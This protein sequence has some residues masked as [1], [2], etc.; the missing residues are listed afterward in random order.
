V[1]PDS[2]S[3][4]GLCDTVESAVTHGLSLA[5]EGADILDIGGESTRPGAPSVEAEVELRRVIPVIEG[6][7]AQCTLPLSVDT[8]KAI[9]AEAALEAGASLVND[10][11]GL[12]F[13]SK[14]ATVVARAGAGLCVMHIQG[15]PQ[16]MQDDPRY[17]NVVPVVEQFLAGAIERAVAAGV[18]RDQ[19]MVDPGI[20]FGKRLED[21]LALIRACGTM[22]Q[23]LGRPV[24]MGVSRK[25]FLGQLTGRPVDER[26]HATGAAVAACVAAGA[27]MVR[28]HDVAAMR[29]VLKVS[30]ALR[31]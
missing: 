26:V 10:I 20:G 5:R 15:T 12:T 18:P 16:T 23:R 3:D 17:E 4:G 22:G 28:V 19:I 24:L 1:T 31:I 21:N 7:R 25:S 13:D 2:F 14:M 30:D 6:L 27:F 11:S 9:V 29:D 8:T